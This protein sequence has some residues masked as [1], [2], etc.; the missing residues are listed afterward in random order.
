MAAPKKRVFLS[1]AAD[2]KQA[3]EQLAEGLRGQSLE[4]WTDA[5]LV[6]GEN[7]AAGMADALGQSDAMVVLLTPR[8][9]ESEWVRRDIDYA[10]SSKRFERR[11]IPVVIGG[12]R[13]PWL[14]KAPWVL[15]KLQMVTSP[16]AAKASKLV[17]DALKKA[18]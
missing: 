7:W 14:A 1:Y 12:E 15:R 16:S 4:V 5:L 9:V 13:A 2:D 11:L 17:A 10:L 6:P 18:G 3:A 8:S